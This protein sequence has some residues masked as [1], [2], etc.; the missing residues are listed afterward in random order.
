MS[1]TSRSLF[2]V[3]ARSLPAQLDD[4]G[5]LADD[6]DVI[7]QVIDRSHYLSPS[8]KAAIFVIQDYNDAGVVLWLNA[9]RSTRSRCLNVPN[10]VPNIVPNFQTLCTEHF[11]AFSALADHPNDFVLFCLRGPQGRFPQSDNYAYLICVLALKHRSQNPTCNSFATIQDIG[12]SDPSISTRRPLRIASKDSSILPNSVAHCPGYSIPNKLTSSFNHQDLPESSENGAGCPPSNTA[13]ATTARTYPRW[14][15]DIFCKRSPPAFTT[16]DGWK[17]HMREH[18]TEW[19]CMP[20]GPTEVTEAGLKCALCGLLDPSE[21]HRTQHQIEQCNVFANKPRKYSRKKGLVKHLKDHGLVDGSAL[22]DKW[23]LTTPKKYF[24]CGFCATIFFNHNDQLNHVDI[25]H[26]KNLQDISD[27]K[28]SKVIEG[29]LQSSHVSPFWRRLW[30]SDSHATIGLSWDKQALRNLQTR[31]EMGEE[32]GE[33]LALATLAK[34]SYYQCDQVNDDS[35]DATDFSTQPL[36]ASPELPIESCAGSGQHL[37]K[38]GL[39]QTDALN[40]DQFRAQP[41]AND[42]SVHT[43]ISHP[44]FGIPIPSTDIPD[45]SIRT[46]Y[47]QNN[48]GVHRGFP[49]NS[50]SSAALLQ[51]SYPSFQTASIPTV[52]PRPL[53]TETSRYSSDASSALQSASTAATSLSDAPTSMDQSADPLGEYCNVDPADLLMTEFDDFDDFPPW[54]NADI[55]STNPQ[56]KRSSLDKIKTHYGV[57]LNFVDN[58]MGAMQD[59][60]QSRSLPRNSLGVYN[61]GNWHS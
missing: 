33:V 47:R 54:L 53:N 1:S 24:S 15:I 44:R 36:N 26:F 27:W 34:S 46:E 40:Q 19:L 7:D 39:Y 55:S 23:R 8:Q 22:A 38:F 12:A 61:V 25:H 3:D 51:P 57:D 20:D 10:I 18:E 56:R 2:S 16:S 14:C 5:S 42:H 35:T 29:L 9:F 28:P 41:H 21:S 52:A 31:L 32:S 58:V 45:G 13:T 60:D 17:R 4:H 48:Y 6:A 37:D 30:P 50:N 11:D 49:T 59:D 43:S